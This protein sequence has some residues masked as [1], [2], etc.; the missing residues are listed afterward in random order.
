MILCA[1]TMY[2]TTLVFTNMHPDKHLHVPDYLTAPFGTKSASN[3]QLTKSQKLLHWLQYY[4]YENKVS[5]D[6]AIV[7]T[8]LS[9]SWAAQQP[10]PQNL[11]LMQA[12]MVL[13]SCLCLEL[14]A[15]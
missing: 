13:V 11:H 1:D 14:P 7:S 8:T 2:H 12:Y 15:P 3:V 10:L 6:M 5:Q 4:F 9:T